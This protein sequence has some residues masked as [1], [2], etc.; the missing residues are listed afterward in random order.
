MFLYVLLIYFILVWTKFTKSI[1]KKHVLQVTC[2]SFS[3]NATTAKL[4]KDEKKAYHPATKSE[5]WRI[6]ALT[7]HPECSRYVMVFEVFDGN[8]RSKILIVPSPN[9]ATNIFPPP[10][11]Y[12]KRSI[13]LSKTQFVRTTSQNQRVNAKKRCRAEVNHRLSQVWSIRRSQFYL[14]L[15]PWHLD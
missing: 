14:I 13:N 3:W 5:D 9:P 10:I 8:R 2:E 6:F 7:M 11:I 4:N 1:H 15:P 12:E